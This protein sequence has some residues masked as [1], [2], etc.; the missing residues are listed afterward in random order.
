MNDSWWR[1]LAGIALGI[2]LAN[3]LATGARAQG[4]AD[5]AVHRLAEAI[6]F[7]TVSHQDP[8][9][10]Q[11]DVF[12]GFHEF[13]ARSFPRVHATLRREVV[14][15]LSL[16]YT[17]PGRDPGRPPI[18]L[19]SHLDVVPVVPE[20]LDDWEHPPFDG[21]VADGFVWGRG[22]LDDKAGVLATLEA[23]EGLL[24]EG[25]AP[26]QTVYLAFG[27]DE[28][29][30]GDEGA[31]AIA[32]QLRE[33]GVRLAFSLDE[34]LVVTEGIVP[35]VTQP[36]ALVG[37]AE[38]GYVTLRIT[39]H[40]AGGHSSRPTS[41][42]AIGKLAAAVTALESSPMPA[43]VEG[44]AAQML[45]AIAPHASFPLGF[46]LGNRALFGPLVTSR[47]AGD[48]SSNALIRTTTAVTMLEA[49]VKEN[50]LPPSASAIVNFRLVP[51]DR[52]QDVLDH[53]AGVAGPEITIDTIRGDEA[54]KVA[55][56]GSPSFAVV[57]RSIEAVFPGVLVAPG[58]VLGGT[59][60]KH[61]G[62]VA[63]QA[64][65]FA[66]VRARSEDLARAHGTNERIAVA[67][68]A[69]MIR[70]YATLVREA[71]R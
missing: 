35:G 69:E 22:A 53:V 32:K 57:R 17:W 20:T 71:E 3:G 44:P 36:V 38:K 70:F 60:T 29:I 6:R 59:D 46:V 7:P 51:G 65:R 34:G 2:G 66:P 64:Y 62:E 31:A 18:L 14:A 61:Y 49:G 55:D 9:Q 27:H 26:A 1:A 8:A 28:E 5:A 40:A 10:R 41:D 16:L 50:V 19:T 4:G 37:I 25:F 30:G 12:L 15:G 48:P 54:S 23:V 47:L 58:L 39:A 56:A 63:E 45:D 33:R 68:Y 24:A 13:L 21:V 52:V 11:R 42:S 67:N 43:R